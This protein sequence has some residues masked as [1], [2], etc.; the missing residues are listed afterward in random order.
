MPDNNWYLAAAWVLSAAAAVLVHRN[1]LV[2]Q[3]RFG[4]PPAGLRPWFWS[5]LVLLF[6]LLGLLCYGISVLGQDR[7][8]R[9]G[10]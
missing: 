4:Q 10:R 7:R 3:E 2:R 8:E 5:L 6:G 1:A 9:E